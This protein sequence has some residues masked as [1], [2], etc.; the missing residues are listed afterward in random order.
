M[1][2]PWISEVS[3]ARTTRRRHHIPGSWYT[4]TKRQANRQVRRHAQLDINEGLDEVYFGPEDDDSLAKLKHD[5][6]AALMLSHHDILRIA[7]NLICQVQSW[8]DTYDGT[9]YTDWF[10]ND[11]I[12]ASNEYGGG[13]YVDRAYHDFVWNAF[14]LFL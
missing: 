8:Q 12:I 11:E 7:L 5:E 3:H 13:I 14:K 1:K 4:Y 6:Q 2:T 9:C 10:H